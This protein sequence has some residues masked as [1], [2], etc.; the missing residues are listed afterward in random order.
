MLRILAAVLLG[1]GASFPAAGQT[2]EPLHLECAGPFGAESSEKFL[3]ELFGSDN[4]VAE[5]IDGPEGTTLDA[6]L[7][8][9]DDPARRLIVLWQDEAN[10]ARPAA[11]IIRDESEWIGPGG[12]RLGSSLEEVEAI[13]GAPFSVLGFGWDYGGAASFPSGTLSAIPGGCIM[14]VSFDLDWSREYGP[15]FDSIMGDQQLGSDNKVL[16]AAAPT[17]SE[18]AVGYPQ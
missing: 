16:K 6:T 7:V 2:G 4:V 18:I 10:R 15:E 9:P 8:F 3:A 12:V 5:T 14:S 13:N 1:V 11:I 17:V